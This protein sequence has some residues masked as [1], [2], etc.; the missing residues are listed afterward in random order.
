MRSVHTHFS[1]ASTTRLVAYRGSQGTLA[2]RDLVLRSLRRFF[3][4]SSPA[5]STFPNSPP[6]TSRVSL[7]ESSSFS[8]PPARR[9]PVSSS[10]RYHGLRTIST[11]FRRGHGLVSPLDAA[12]PAAES[13]P[14][15]SQEFRQSPPSRRR[16]EWQ[17]HHR[18][19]NEAAVR[20]DVGGPGENRVQGELS[21]CSPV[22][23]LAHI[24]SKDV[25]WGADCSFRTV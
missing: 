15:Q 25:I 3:L 19:A 2:L 13:R 23:D 18:Q 10:P 21:A 22:S 24:S 14:R 12:R 1:P 7:H 8:L 11:S 20:Q 4:F 5:T 6:S 17:E 9:P 16:R